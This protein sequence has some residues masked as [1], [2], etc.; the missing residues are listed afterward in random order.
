MQTLYPSIM[1]AVSERFCESWR[2]DP[3]GEEVTWHFPT[4]VQKTANIFVQVGTD[5]ATLGL[6]NDNKEHWC[7]LTLA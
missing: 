2:V 6:C 4:A 7:L 5:L 1:H 3:L